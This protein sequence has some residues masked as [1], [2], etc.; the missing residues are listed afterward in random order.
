MD[1]PRGLRTVVVVVLLSETE[2][3]TEERVP[4]DAEQVDLE[5]P[6]L[7]TG[8][9]SDLLQ[10][11][12][13]GRVRTALG[14]GDDG[15]GL[16]GVEVELDSVEEADGGVLRLERCG[17]FGSELG[18]HFF[19]GGGVGGEGIRDTFLREREREMGGTFK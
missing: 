5:H 18:F 13:T 14:P 8:V 16:S 17:G 6:H 10:D 7:G 12:A 19:L 11:R 1:R 15:A 3:E 9:P 4:A 2:I